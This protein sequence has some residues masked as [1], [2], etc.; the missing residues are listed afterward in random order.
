MEWRNQG[1]DEQGVY[2]G[3][4]GRGDSCRPAGIQALSAKPMQGYCATLR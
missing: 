4:E 1:T 2:K 3:A